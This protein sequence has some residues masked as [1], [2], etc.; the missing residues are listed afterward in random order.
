M[1]E[2]GEDFDEEEMVVLEQVE[3]EGFEEKKIFDVEMEM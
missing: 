1:M 2:G 3:F